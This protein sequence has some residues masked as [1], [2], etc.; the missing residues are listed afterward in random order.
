MRA[1]VVEDDP[2]VRD[3]I[4]RA[5]EGG[6]YD[7][8]AVASGA[9][10]D[11]RAADG[12]F[13]LAVIDWNVPDI[14]GIDVVRRLRS[15]KDDTPVLMVTARDAVDDRV[16]GL[17]CG[18]DDYLV[19]PFHVEELLARVRSVVRRKGSQSAARFVEGALALDTAARSV[20]V[21]GR[22]V[23]LT[24]REY[25]LLEFLMLNAG[26]ALSR[27]DIEERVWGATFE[28]SSNVLDVMI[29]RLRR[30]LGTKASAAIETVRRHGYRFKRSAEAA[31]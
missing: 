31:P 29:G 23:A 8:I 2:H 26:I 27:V 4:V 6:G 18:A 5:L 20:S 25:E 21:A 15:A 3:V 14:S 12:G 22:A 28:G 16:T 13:D 9:D 30:K 24:A 10:G 17:D 11:A 1:L 19:K 7:V